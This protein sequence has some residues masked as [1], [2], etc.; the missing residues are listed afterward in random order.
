MKT[1]SEFQLFYTIYKAAFKIQLR[2][3]M[4]A[5]GVKTYEATYSS[6]KNVGSDKIFYLF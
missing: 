2:I 1:D 6:F 3:V 5:T 4:R